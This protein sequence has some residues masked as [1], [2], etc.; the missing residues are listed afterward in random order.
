VRTPPLENPAAAANCKDLK[1]AA[2]AATEEAAVHTATLQHFE[3]ARAWEPGMA[4]WQQAAAAV[5]LLLLL[6]LLFL[7]GTQLGLLGMGLCLNRNHTGHMGRYTMHP[8]QP[9]QATQ[10][11]T[12]P[13]CPAAG[14]SILCQRNN[15]LVNAFLCRLKGGK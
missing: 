12:T 14:T 15:I 2:V 9:G 3:S 1:P 10:H 13:F 6:L 11:P 8:F 7:C 4:C 5:L